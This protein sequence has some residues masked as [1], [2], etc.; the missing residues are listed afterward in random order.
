MWRER[1]S[2]EFVWLR[3]MTSSEL[4]WIWE[5]SKTWE[6]FLRRMNYSWHLKKNTDLAWSFT[7]FPVKFVTRVTFRGAILQINP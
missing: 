6:K 7:L 3:I 5:L 4:L 1:V 2:N